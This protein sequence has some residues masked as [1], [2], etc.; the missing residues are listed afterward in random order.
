MKVDM[1]YDISDYQD[2]YPPYG[3]AAECDQLIEEVHK[4]G[5]KIIFDLVINH[6]S[7]QHQ[8]FKESRSSRDNPKRDWYIWR[9]PRYDEH[10]QRKPPNNWKSI[11][12]GMQLFNLLRHSIFTK[13]FGKDLPGNTMKPPTNT[14]CTYLSKNSRI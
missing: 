13:R 14:T 2:I 6:S 7:D 11:F 4:R 1:G 10:G 5:M 8:W 12:Q 3:T 9:P